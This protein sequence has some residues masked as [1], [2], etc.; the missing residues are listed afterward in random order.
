MVISFEAGPCCD[1]QIF[2]GGDYEMEW[3]GDAGNNDKLLLWGSNVQQ[4][5]Q[6]VVLGSSGTRVMSFTVQ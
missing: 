1:S 2:N 4:T 3:L 5:R 6:T